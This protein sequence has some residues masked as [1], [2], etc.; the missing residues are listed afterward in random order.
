MALVLASAP[1]ED[2]PPNII[3]ILTDDQGWSQISTKMDPRVARSHSDYLETP[4]LTRLANHGMRFTNAYSPAP[5]CTPTRRS[6]LCGTSAPRSGTEFASTW[7]PNDHLTIPMALKQANANYRCAHFGKWGENMGA[8]PKDCGYDVSDGD[9]GNAEGGSKITMKRS[10]GLKPYYINNKDPKLTSSL[11]DRSIEFLQE[12][13]DSKQPFYLQLSYYAVHKAITCKESTL[14]KY[15]KKGRPDRAYPPAW[16]AMLEEMDAGIGRLVDEVDALGLNQNTYIFFTSDNGGSATHYGVTDD[17]TITT[18]SPLFGAKQTLYEGGIRVPFIVRGPGIKAG[19][20]CHTPVVGYDFLQTFYELAG[21]TAKLPDEID[22]L[23]IR[24]LLAD[25]K[26]GL[27]RDS[28]YFHRPGKRYSAIRKKHLK[29]MLVWN[30]DGTID[31]HEL[32]RVGKKPFEKNRD[33][34]KEMPQVAKELRADL[35]AYLKKVD[36]ETVADFPPKKRKK[37]K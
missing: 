23:S 13:A 25:P 24:S 16:A 11:T 18:N 19:T 22:G 33:V 31:H 32:Y 20:V 35:L 21:G 1:A 15:N 4:S 34:A 2:I 37:K 3:L 29:L 28:L 14:A 27:A 10:Q 5:L 30:V 17:F 9:T 36:A 26:S 6:I 12:Q 7:V 8:T